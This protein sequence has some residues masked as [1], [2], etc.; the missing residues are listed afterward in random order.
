MKILNRTTYKATTQRPIK[1]LQ[2]GE[3]NF[4]RGFVD[5]IIEIFNEKTDF[6]GDIQIVQPIQT[7][8]GDLINEQDGLYHV[9]IEGLQNGEKVQYTKLISCVRGA[10]NPFEDYKAFLKLGKNKDLEFIVSNTTEAGII[11]DPNDKSFETLPLTFPGKLTALLYYRFLHFKDVQS[12]PLTILPCELIDRNGDKLKS[13]ILKYIE[14]WELPEGF[15]IWLENRI[16]FCNTLVDRIVPGFPHD[17][18]EQI[19][20]KIGYKDNLVVKTEPF[21]L[22]VI[23]S[24]KSIENQFPAKEAE[25][26]IKFVSDLTPYRTRKVRILNGAHTAMVPVGYLSGMQTVKETL[27]HLK[28]APFVNEVIFDEIIP[29][30]DL[31]E[32]ELILFANSVIERFKNPFV[33]HQLIS[34]A[35]N[36]IS[37]FKV[38]V[39]P[40]L[41]KYIELNQKL[42]KNLVRSL[43]YLILFYR[44][45]N[46]ENQDIPLQ[47]DQNILSFFSEVW[48]HKD[49]DI[50]I[51][52]VLEN[53]M[54]WGKN[55]S[56]IPTLKDEIIKEINIYHNHN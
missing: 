37:K 44:G 29:T 52:K 47:D 41:L 39:L 53:E 30:L 28:T 15:T 38:R 43:A 56:E 48:Q 6:N 24:P 25:L 26:S 4:L 11:F 5:W 13:A 20:K 49:L 55:L 40:S 9:L 27:E 50:T 23:E 22:W 42:P 8:L 18:I 10:I 2:F 17:T 3:G 14:L 45:K 46:F 7:G 31:P 33:K 21:H 35:L 32:E 16:V 12:K 54:L 1:V 34:I 36:S 51:Q 19:Q